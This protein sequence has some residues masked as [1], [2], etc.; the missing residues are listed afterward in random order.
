MLVELN[1]VYI[2]GVIKEAE[3]LTKGNDD[4]LEA[5]DI[6]MS[7]VTDG[8]IQKL[9]GEDSISTVSKAFTHQGRT[10]QAIVFYKGDQSE[11]VKAQTL[12]RQTVEK[13]T[14]KIPNRNTDKGPFSG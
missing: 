7:Y 1:K 5:T 2:I 11:K 9:E 3:A 6:K 10:M 4:F 13:Y 14:K 8:A 12:V